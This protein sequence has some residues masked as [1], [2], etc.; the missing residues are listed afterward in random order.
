MTGDGGDVLVIDG[1]QV[2][3][4]IAR[5][6]T[7]VSFREIA[8]YAAAI[9]ADRDIYL[10]DRTPGGACAPPSFITAAEWPLISGKEALAA[11]GIEPG[12]LFRHLLH[13]FQDTWFGQTL[14]AGDRL[15][16]EA[17]L[18]SVRPVATGVLVVTRVVSTHVGSGTVATESW[19]GAFYRNAATPH[20]VRVLTA[21]VLQRWGESAADEMLL[22]ALGR[23]QAHIYA[24]CA[25]LW[26]PIHTE[27]SFAESLGLPDIALHGTLV[28]AMVGEAAIDRYMGRDP[29]R[30]RRLGM[31]FNRPMLPG[32]GMTLRISQSTGDVRPF[33]VLP[34]PI[35]PHAS[36]EPWQN[37]L[38]EGVFEWSEAA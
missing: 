22:P 4:V 1:G 16:Q 18:A 28:W 23:G 11:L 35:G 12:K 14:R 15:R 9:G 21:P 34:P 8:A 13:G 24:E 36:T 17:V 2:G 38:A 27:P 33:A 26:N 31:R 6:E 25:R 7:T 10:D 32:A 5:R 30:L 20:L 3:Q 29:T 37:P 19:F